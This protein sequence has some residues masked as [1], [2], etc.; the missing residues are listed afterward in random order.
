MGASEVAPSRHP[1]PR[2]AKQGAAALQGPQRHWSGRVSGL[3]GYI[4]PQ[5]VSLRLVS[6]VGG[7]ARED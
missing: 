1:A 5:T 4:R 3:G 7:F 6:K 2:C